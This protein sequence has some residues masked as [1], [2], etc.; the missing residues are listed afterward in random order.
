VLQA[1]LKCNERL[2]ELEKFLKRLAG[3]SSGTS[4][5][6]VKGFRLNF[7]TS[8]IHFFQSEIEAYK[9]KSR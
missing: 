3:N 4:N 5:K 2:E 7:A 9:K 1:I 6:I 8:D